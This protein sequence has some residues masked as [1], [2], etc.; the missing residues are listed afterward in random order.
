VTAKQKPYPSLPDTLSTQEMCDLLGI[1]PRSLRDMSAK[2]KIQQAPQKGRYFTSSITTYCANLRE[3]AANRRSENG[4]S[5]TEE[6]AKTEAITRQIA[7]IKLKQARG[8]MLPLDEVEQAWG[9]LAR[10]VSGAVMGIASKSR[11]EI[12]HL[13]AHDAETLKNI[14]RDVLDLLAEDLEGGA[15]IGAE[16]EALRVGKL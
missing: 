6:R 9:G 4:L 7:E 15:V 2:G 8:E 5:L 10:A 14:C 1:G 11:R 13:T 16:P 3:V 12:P